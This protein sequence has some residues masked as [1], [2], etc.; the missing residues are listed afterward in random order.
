MIIIKKIGLNELYTEACKAYPDH[1]ITLSGNTIKI[2]KIDA[3][4]KEQVT[5][6]TKLDS[7]IT[8]EYIKEVV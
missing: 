1:E 8:S 2:R 4:G 6:T 7:K 3:D 5:D